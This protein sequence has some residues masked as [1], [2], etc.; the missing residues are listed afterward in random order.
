MTYRERIADL[1]GESNA[2]A[3]YG[4]GHDDARL[5]AAAI[6]AEADAEIARLRAALTALVA[7]LNDRAVGGFV[8]CGASVWMDANAALA[9][10][11]GEGGE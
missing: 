8:D 2:G 10:G 7:D 1:T 4:F 3:Y 6:A 11:A 5:A 9:P